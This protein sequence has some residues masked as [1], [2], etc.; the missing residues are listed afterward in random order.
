MKQE[1]LNVL[2]FPCAV[3]DC[4]AAAVKPGGSP[5][6]YICVRYG[7]ARF[8]WRDIDIFDEPIR[9]RGVKA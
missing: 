1:A 5:A 4:V 2:L 7:S 6:I 8:P 9:M 3:F